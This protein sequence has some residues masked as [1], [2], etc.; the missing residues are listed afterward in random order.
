MV[1]LLASINVNIIKPMISIIILDT[2]G[3]N[4]FLSIH[5]ANQLA[6]TELKNNII[7]NLHSYVFNLSP[8][9]EYLLPP[10]YDTQCFNYEDNIGINGELG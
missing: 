2:K 9:T 10:P 4:V 6:T 8:K 1:D 3:L 7:L 5:P